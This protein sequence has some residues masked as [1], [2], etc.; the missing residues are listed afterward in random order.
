MGRAADV[1]LRTI[2]LNDGHLGVS[3]GIRGYWVGV[4]GAVGDRYATVT[5]QRGMFGPTEDWAPVDLADPDRFRRVIDAA[6]R[7]AERRHEARMAL[8]APEVT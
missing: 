6:E 4:T 5:I 7:E 2:E 1:I 8:Y 3:V